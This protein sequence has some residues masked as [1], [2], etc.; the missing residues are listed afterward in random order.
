MAQTTRVWADTVGLRPDD[1]YLIVSP[2]FHISGH[3]TGVL[4]C[5]TVGATM[6]PLPAF[7]PDDTL[8]LVERERVTVLPGPPT[9]YHSLLDHPARERHD[10]SSLRLA[11][12]GA[13]SVPVELVKRVRAELPFEVVITAYGLTEATG[14]VTMCRPDDPPEVIA[15]TSGVP[16]A[17]VEL[18]LA[19]GTDEVLVRGVGVMAGYLDDPAATAEAIDADGWL[20][21]GDVGRLSETGHL[22]ITD[23]LKDLYISGG[24]N[25]YPAEVED[26]LL[27][28]AGVGQ[29]A[30]IGVADERM[31]EVGHAFVVRRA[32]APE[33]DEATLTAESLIAWSREHMANYKVPRGVTFLDAL[34]TNAAG[35][36]TK[37]DLRGLREDGPRGVPG[38]R[39][40]RR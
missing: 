4:A 35:K 5:V 33:G 18:R 20:H 28:H 21:T 31:G 34:P 7:T 9:L 24:F 11:V 37:P 8:A 27:R 13:A 10:L 32:G 40:P 15:E 12:T 3:K 19:E 2:F 6:I 36:V 14:V 1:R 16:I 25:V 22:T 29:A 30:V 39:Q 23:R 17:G 26:L 38:D